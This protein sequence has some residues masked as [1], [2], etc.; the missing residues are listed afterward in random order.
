MARQFRTL[1]LVL[2][3][4]AGAC[5]SEI[6]RTPISFEQSAGSDQR[7]IQIRELVTID[8]PTGYQRS[9]LTGSR[10]QKVGRTPAG[11]VYRPVGTV[12][13]IEGAN[14]HEAYLVLRDGRLVGFYLPGERAY[15]TMPTEVLLPFDP[16]D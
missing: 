16:I 4:L 3:A 2:G 8:L 5:A 13:T 6:V 9:I 12:F 7:R 11:D 14:N 15:S 10:W 1:I